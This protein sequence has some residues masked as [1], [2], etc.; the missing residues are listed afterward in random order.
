MSI[1]KVKK[2]INSAIADEDIKILDRIVDLY[3]SLLKKIK[4]VIEDDKTIPLWEYIKVPHV[5][6]ISELAGEISENMWELRQSDITSPDEEIIPLTEML[7]IDH[8][9]KEIERSVS[10]YELRDM[11][12]FDQHYIYGLWNI[13]KQELDDFKLIVSSL[14][15]SKSAYL[16]RMQYEN[17]KRKKKESAVKRAAA[18]KEK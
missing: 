17:E 7:K 4:F 18:A 3:T 12:E 5:K 1:V 14:E 13:F 15:Y 6:K 2:Y 9:C 8:L 10:T 11:H 16:N